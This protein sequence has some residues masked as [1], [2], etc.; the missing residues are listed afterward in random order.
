MLR[1]RSAIIEVVVTT[2]MG[3]VGG[4][5]CARADAWKRRMH[6][7]RDTKGV[8]PQDAR[9]NGSDDD[10]IIPVLRAPFER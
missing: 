3:L 8:S 2:E 6:A 5:D 9:T 7:S 4:A 10:L 1:A